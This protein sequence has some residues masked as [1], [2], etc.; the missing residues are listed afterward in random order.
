MSAIC[1][2]VQCKKP[3]EKDSLCVECENVLLEKGATLMAKA[4][5]DFTHG[6]QNAPGSPAAAI[7]A[8]R[9]KESS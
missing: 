5:F 3:W 4:M 8:Y 7:R 2:C 9:K 1:S 6:D